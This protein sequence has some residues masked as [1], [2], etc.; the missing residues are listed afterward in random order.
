M[1]RVPGRAAPG[2]GSGLEAV[3]DGVVVLVFV[4]GVVV[5]DRIQLY[6]HGTAKGTRGRL[7]TDPGFPNYAALSPG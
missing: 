3:H 2:P 1:R 7:L 6:A 5:Q 4:L